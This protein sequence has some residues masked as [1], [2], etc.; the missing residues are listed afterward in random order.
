MSASGAITAVLQP[1]L[2]HASTLS[3]W[4]ALCSAWR[5][6]ML[7]ALQV[8]HLPLGGD[9]LEGWAKLPGEVI[10]CPTLSQPCPVGSHPQPYNP[11][12]CFQVPFHQ[13]QA[14]DDFCQVELPH[15]ASVGLFMASSS[16]TALCLLMELSQ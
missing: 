16:R 13:S 12:F 3:R 10:P 7:T 6:A 9:R 15:N 14:S 2:S 11:G 8:S 1:V 4:R 5:A